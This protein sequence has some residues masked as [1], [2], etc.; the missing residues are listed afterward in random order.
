M[1]ARLPLRVLAAYYLAAGLWPVVHLASFEAVTGAKT[2]DW[3]VR[4]VGWLAA[5]IGVALWSGAARADRT[6][7]V[8][9]FSAIAAFTGVDVKYVLDGTLRAVYL[10]DAATELAM[11]AWLALA[12]R[13]TRSASG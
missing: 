9:A 5:A 11:A 10:A 4:T 8:L 3:L 6:A 2:D 7:R 1:R 13:G 12:L